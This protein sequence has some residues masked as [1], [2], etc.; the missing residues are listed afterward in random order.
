MRGRDATEGLEVRI[1]EFCR[2]VRASGFNVGVKETEDALNGARALWAAEQSG[3]E[4]A[5]R[6][7]LCSSKEEWER[8]PDL[9]HD[10]WAGANQTV[11][12][13]EMNPGS[14]PGHSDLTDSARKAREVA[15]YSGQETEDESLREGKSIAG[16][17]AVERLKRAD[18]TSVPHQ[19][20]QDL[21][22]LA[23]RLLGQMC[24]RLSR[25]LRTERK[26][27][28]DLRRTIRSSIGR[29][30]DPIDLSFRGRKKQ[31]PRLVIFID[32]SGSMEL[33]SLFLVRFAF[34]LHK[35][36]RSVHTFVFS[37]RALDVTAA[38][39]S[40]S[41]DKT[42]GLLGGLPAGWS[43]G[44]RIGESLALVNRARESRLLSRETLFIIFSDGLETGDPTQ[45]AAEMR[46]IKQRARK[47]VWLNPL[48]GMENYR[49][50]ARGMKAALPYI[51]CLAAANSL[52]SLL[53]L[54]DTLAGMLSR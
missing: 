19:D 33:Y 36:F 53:R 20:L 50:L 4:F 8:F 54:E 38:L 30:G 51:D 37:T 41:L 47:V 31:E 29:G 6:A 26:G 25:R 23:E 1:V 49:P 5:L 22:R 16:A 32:V 46:A 27:R 43:G 9:F 42:L 52:K 11:T 18:F 48:A 44:T 13:H 7:T 24:L 2:F 15:L 39:N 40:R 17:S 45:L 34:A 3:L 10:F 21:E 14:K 35:V 28:I 12:G